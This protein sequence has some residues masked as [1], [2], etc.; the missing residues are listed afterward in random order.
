MPL[1]RVRLPARHHQYEIKIGPDLL[2][3]LGREARASLG[4]KARRIA[5]I[6]NRTIF[7]LFGKQANKSLRGAGFAPA[8]WLMKDGERYK[9][10]RSLERALAFLSE[11]RLERT[12][13]I[14]A[15]GGGVV[16]DLA[17]F[18]AATYLRGMAFIQVP[19][20]LL[21]QIDASRSEE[22]TSELQSP[23]NL[24]CRLLLE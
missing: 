3:E 1:V 9:S 8:A 18:A 24:V 17:G 21:A 22:H 5:V 20:T 7:D 16:G 13:A 6:S 19:T 15:L 23:C 2:S 10:L 12:D 14:V 4:P 11:A